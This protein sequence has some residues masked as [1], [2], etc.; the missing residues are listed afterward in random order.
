M[1]NQNQIL[2]LKLTAR[3]LSKGKSYDWNGVSIWPIKGMYGG[4][5]WR[6]KSPL[7]ELTANHPMEAALEFM[8]L[9]QV[10]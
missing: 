3:G 9:V 4:V 10:F 6:I 8:K 5:T 7:G 1:M 2:A